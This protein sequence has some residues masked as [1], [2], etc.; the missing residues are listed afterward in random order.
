MKHM[1]SRDSGWGVL[2]L[3]SVDAGRDEAM[4]HQYMTAPW[5]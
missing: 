4:L 1:P 2:F 3:L 5:N